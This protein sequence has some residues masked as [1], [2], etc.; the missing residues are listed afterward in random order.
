MCTNQQIKFE[1][2]LAKL[3]N[4]SYNDLCH[5]GKVVALCN[6]NKEPTVID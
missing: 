6:F 5:Y 2:V 1:K 4:M 3:F